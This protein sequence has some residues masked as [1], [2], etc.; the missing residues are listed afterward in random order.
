MNGRKNEKAITLVALVVTI[1]VLLILVSVSISMLTGDNGIVKQATEAKKQTSIASE[2]EAIGLY[3]LGKGL[4]EDNS[5]MIGEKLYDKNIE[6][7]T[8]WK[9]IMIKDTNKVYGTGWRYIVP[10]TEIK[11]YGDA[12]HK[13]IYNEKTGETIQLEEDN[14]VELSYGMNLAVKDDLIF[15][16]DPINMENENSWGNIKLHGFNGTEKDENG[17]I[18]SGFSGN[19]FNFDGVDDWIE[20]PKEQEIGNTGITIESYGILDEESIKAGGIYVGPVEGS[21]AAFKYSVG[22]GE[23]YCKEFGKFFG[24]NGVFVQNI[25]TGSKYQ[26][27]VAKNDWHVVLDKNEVKGE[28]YV[29]FSLQ[30]N[31]EFFIMRNGEVVAKDKFNEEYVKNYNKY[32]NDKRYSIMLGRSANWDAYCYKMKTYTTRLYAKPLTEEEAKENQE[33]TIAYHKL[34]GNEK[35]E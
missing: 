20:I 25:P 7:G 32:L 29:T 10:G 35:I 9:L 4:S 19:S 8:K 24:V 22:N 28:E 2:K 33:K 21:T 30:P 3:A 13:W 34:I 18:I 31:G 5:N 23:R 12:T 27:N 15:N 14:F 6:N 1:V 11:D 26:C 17:N 16:L